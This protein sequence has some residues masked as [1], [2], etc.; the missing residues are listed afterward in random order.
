MLLNTI[1][2]QRPVDTPDEPTGYRVGIFA[3]GGG[4][5]P[6]ATRD[7][8]ASAVTPHVEPGQAK[9]DLTSWANENPVAE[10]TYAFRVKA[11]QTEGSE[12]PWGGATGDFALTNLEPPTAV[13]V[14]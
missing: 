1:I 13:S 9:I 12:S 4:G 6:L 2:F 7:F 5:S 3:A 8:A 14:S 10:G 11:L